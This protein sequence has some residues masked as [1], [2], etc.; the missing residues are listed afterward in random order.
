MNSYK[1]YIKQAGEWQEVTTP[2]FPFSWGELLDER[3]DEAYVTVY[4]R[5]EQYNRL[6]RVRVTIHNGNKVRDEYFAI[7]SDSATESPV[8]SGR[9]KHDLYLI[10]LMKLT[11]GIIC[12]SITFTNAK[13]KEYGGKIG[14]AHG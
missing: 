14:R 9:Y 2:V 7:A 3:L 8:G 13:G 11:E 6:D 10:E 1:L 12:S 4:S 5:V